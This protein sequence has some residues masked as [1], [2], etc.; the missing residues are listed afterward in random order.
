MMNGLH[1][2]IG[3]FIKFGIV[4]IS[5]TLISLA[6]Y[7]IFIFIDKDLYLA[8]SIAGFVVSVLNSYY[9]NNRYVFKSEKRN[10]AQAIAKTFLSYGSTSIL[11]TILLVVIVEILSISEVIAPLI[12]LIITVPLNFILNKFWAYK[13]K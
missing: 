1:N 9:W 6:I 7:Y 3:Q 13:D 2:L 12:N 5:N 11:S 10:H 8:G 4:G